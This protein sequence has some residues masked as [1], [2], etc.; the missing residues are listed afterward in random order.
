MQD[1]QLIERHRV[2]DPHAEVW[3][4][5]TVYHKSWFV[6]INHP[7]ADDDNEGTAA[8]PLKHIQAAVNRAQP[9]EEVV[10]AQG[11]YRE[12][13]IIP[14]GG[15]DS[16]QMIRLRPAEGAQVTISGAEPLRGHWHQPLPEGAANN[17]GKT[18]GGALGLSQRTWV[19]DVDEVH[20]A[21]DQANWLNPNTTAKDVAI[22][23]WMQ[24]VEGM[25]SFALRRCML[26]QGQRRLTQLSD[27]NDV[28]R[29]A[30][31]FA[32]HA[33]NRQI[34]INPFDFVIGQTPN[35]DHFEIAVRSIG[36]APSNPAV[37][38]VSLQGLEVTR[39]ANGFLRTTTGAICNL[40]GSHWR[41]EYCT[42]HS[43]N[44]S[45]VECSDLASEYKDRDNPWRRH[46]GAG[47][48][49]ITHN[50]IFDCGTA[51]IRSHIVK[52]GRI[53]FNRIHD[54]GW[55]EAEYYFECAGMKILLANNTLI[56]G[57]H[58][59]DIQGGCGIWV[60][61][62]AK[63][64][65]V[66]ENIIHDIEGMQG[67]IFLEASYD[68]N[69]VDHNFI[70]RTSGFGIF[71][72][73]SQNQLYEYNIIGETHA[74][75]VLLFCHTE[76][77][78]NKH[79]AVCI[80]NHVRKNLCYEALAFDVQEQPNYLSENRILAATD[81]TIAILKGTSFQ[82][83]FAQGFDPNMGPTWLGDHHGEID[84]TA[85]IIH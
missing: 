83:S 68:L 61:W 33:N 3:Q 8:A 12:S 44:S 57:N 13:V 9:G 6:D 46:R 30:G 80:H 72:G 67:A 29:V 74:A 82:W 1:A 14:R 2:T 27:T 56:K 16:D 81:E 40:G 25:A 15:T 35:P 39:V 5:S 43:I 62:D 79:P 45:G 24:P 49:I 51:G 36:I 38:F 75:S 20:L 55:Q 52:H 18:F 65:R 41:V 26:F 4:D 54:C 66:T 53:C 42:V 34:V 22:M 11:L 70:W 31:S 85:A 48:T 78:V 60:D 69:I 37:N 21:E 63:F 23:E 58:I 84:L 32:V 76:R 77:K 7:Q 50:H 71:G 64:T 19:V 47:H 59:S 17:S 28:A 73:D 10:I